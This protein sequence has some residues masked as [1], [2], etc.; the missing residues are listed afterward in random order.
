MKRRGLNARDKYGDNEDGS[1]TD[2]DS[3][4]PE[5]AGGAIALQKPLAVVH[6]P[7]SS[8]EGPRG[9]GPLRRQGLTRQGSGSSPSVTHLRPGANAADMNLFPGSRR[10][11]TAV[12]ASERLSD[13]DASHPRDGF[14]GPDGQVLGAS[15]GPWRRR[16]AAAGCF[17]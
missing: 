12:D 10:W 14:V 13:C 11:P 3:R 17:T 8:K 5:Q 7:R 16:S 9:I 2:L 1:L 15:E 6:L 4:N